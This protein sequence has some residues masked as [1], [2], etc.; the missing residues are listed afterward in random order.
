MSVSVLKGASGCAPAFGVFLRVP[1]RAIG[2][3][4]PP[5]RA[6]CLSAQTHFALYLDF[7]RS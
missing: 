6:L 1:D 5:C 7:N 4:S 2:M 3:Y